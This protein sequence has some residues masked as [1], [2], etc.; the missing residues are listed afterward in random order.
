MASIAQGY[1]DIGLQYGVKLDYSVK[2]LVDLDD[3]IH[4]NYPNGCSL[5]TTIISV[6]AYIGEVI[7]RTLH[8]DWFHEDE[9][10]PPCVMI[11]R[12]RANVYHWALKVLGPNNSDESLAQKYQALESIIEQNRVNMCMAPL[13]VPT[14]KW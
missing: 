5:P 14:R 12:V 1:A 2:S 13:F 9:S 3:Y 11:G 7:V 10:S 6:S 4:T 8:G